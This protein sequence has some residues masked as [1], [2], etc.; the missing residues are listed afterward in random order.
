[1]SHSNMT[2]KSVWF[3][4]PILL[5]CAAVHPVSADD[6]VA[7]DTTASAVWRD[8]ILGP[9]GGEPTSATLPTLEL[10]RQDYEQL[11]IGRS[12]IQ[13]PLSLGDRSFDH[14]L[15]TH[16]VSHIRIQSQD[17]IVRFS[18]IVGVDLNDNNQGERGTVEFVVKCKDQELFRSGVMR[19]VSGGK[20]VDIAVPATEELNLHVTDAGDG[21]AY[22]HANWADARITTQSGRTY[23]LDQLPLAETTALTLPY[24]FSFLYDGQPVHDLL[25][26][27]KCET[28]AD[29]SDPSRQQSTTIWTDS[30]T[31]LRVTFALTRFQDFPAAEWLLWFE[32][33]GQSDTKI[34]ADV[35]AGDFT[36]RSPRRSSEPYLLHR[37]HGGTYDPLQLAASTDTI[38]QKQPQELTAGGGRSSTVDLP[39]FKI[40]TQRGSVIVAVGWSGCWKAQLTTADNRNLHVTAGL[41]QTHFLLRPGEKVRSPRMLAFFQEG[42]S[43]E[44]NARF[45]ELIYHHYAARRSGDPLLPMLFCNT[46]F[47]RG[48]GWLNEC[49]AANQISLIK[50]YAPLGLEALLTDAGWFEGGW[51][52]GA[53]NWTPRKDAYPEGMA[54]VAAAAREHGM[55][56]GLWYEP[57]RVVANTDLHR[58]HPDWLLRRQEAPDHTYLLNF[59]LPE[60]QDHFFEIVRD[61]MELPGFR[62]YRQDFNMDPL[63]YWRHSDAPDRQGVSEMK[64]I[65]GLYAYWD[66]IATTWPDSIREECA[67]GGHRMDLETVMRMHLHQKTDYW[68]NNDVDQASLWGASQYLPNNTIVAHLNRLDDYSFHSTL[69]SSLCLGWIADAEDFDV[70]RAKQ[71]TDRYLAVRHLLVGSWYPLLP[72]SRNDVDWTGMQFHRAD[73]D[74]GMLLVFRRAESPYRTADLRL[75]GLVEDASYEIVSDTNGVLGTFSGA[76]LARQGLPV[77]LS[78]HP[79]SDLLIYRRK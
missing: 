68:F 47:T 13:T 50:A 66:R 35:N 1:M 2:P 31:S 75:R 28:Q 19:C 25:K 40:D 73:L 45:R 41:E 6:N 38:D 63:P 76:Q 55:V 78:E 60:V 37:T 36:L 57:E 74:E 44:A 62:F 5:V 3:A 17:P 7:A 52:N 27:W 11:E 69:A 10:V 34:I 39:F 12:V 15:G 43:W 58:N 16:S 20:T 14:G 49:N 54:P 22:D 67:S 29:T 53:G 70:A 18:A 21:P 32:N 23:W 30:Q 77:T 26:S 71:L 46:C 79:K 72:Y 61:F 4:A 56:Y 65:E 42:D 24:P 9:G 64:Y 59:G 51:P 33:V 8:T 48:G